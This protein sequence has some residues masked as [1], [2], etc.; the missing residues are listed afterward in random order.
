RRPYGTQL[1]RRR[2]SRDAPCATEAEFGCSNQEARDCG[3]SQLMKSPARFPAAAVFAAIVGAVTPGAAQA[4]AAPQQP[5]LLQ[6]YCI[7]CHNQRLKTGGLTID[8]MDFDHFALDSGS[9]DKVV[10]KISMGMMRPSE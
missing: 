1:G 6:Q 10:R 9:W 2:V 3:S 5:A 7:T 4:P 8:T